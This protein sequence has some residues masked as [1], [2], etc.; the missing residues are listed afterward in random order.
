MITEIDPITNEL[1]AVRAK[2]FELLNNSSSTNEPRFDSYYKLAIAIRPPWVLPKI[3]VGSIETVDLSREG[4]KI[5]RAKLIAV[6][7]GKYAL[8]AEAIA[9]IIH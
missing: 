6:D 3:K 8:V 5:I 7:A 4:L 2:I 9:T 1:E